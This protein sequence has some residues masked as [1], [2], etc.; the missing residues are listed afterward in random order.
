MRTELANGTLTMYPEG[1]INSQN[2]SEFEREAMAV[3]D[4][5]RWASVVVDAEQLVY[6]SSAGLRVLMRIMRRAGN[7]LQVINVLPEVYDVFDVT[8]FTDLMDVR[9][10]GR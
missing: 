7:R 3:V 4:G 6:I 10:R 9:E 8:G 5:V 2:A 1:H